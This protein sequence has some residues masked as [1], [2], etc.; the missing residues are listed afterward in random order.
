MKTNVAH[1]PSPQ[2]RRL[3]EL[4][5]KTAELERELYDARESLARSSGAWEAPLGHTPELGQLAMDEPGYGY[6]YADS[7]SML[8]VAPGPAESYPGDRPGDADLDGADERTAVLINRGRASASPKRLPATA[9]VS[10]G[11]AVVMGLILGVVVL[12]RPGPA[13]S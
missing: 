8:G 13:P 4:E 3:A 11:V 1:A 2:S 10:M 5:Q 12:T 7:A 6:G 9:K